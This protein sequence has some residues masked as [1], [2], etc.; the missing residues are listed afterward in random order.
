[1][2]R[3]LL[4]IL[5]VF[6]LGLIAVG[7]TFSA[8]TRGPAEFVLN[9]GTEPKSLDPALM[10]G[11][12]EGR[13][14]EG[15]FEGLA[16][17]EAKSLEP[18]PAAA[19]SWEISPD[20][21]R[22]VFHIR[23]EARWSDGRKLTAGDFAYAWRR[24]QDPSLGAEYAYI[25]HMVRYAEA[26]NLYEGQAKLLETEIAPG[27]AKLRRDN[28]SGVSP[29]AWTAFIAKHPI[30]ANIKGSPD[31]LLVEFLGAQSPALDPASLEKL[32]AAL[33]EEARRRRA[34][35]EE[36][37][38][39]FGVDGGVF[40]KDER[41]LVVELVAPTPYF[42]EIAAFYPTYPVPRWLVEAEGSEKDWF[43]PEKIVSNGAFRLVEWRVGDR[44]R[45]ER[46]ETYWGKDK[47]RLRSVDILPIEN[48]TTSLN[49]YL[50]GD[51]DWIPSNRY[52]LDLADKLKDR[53]DFYIGPALI[54][55]YYRINTTRKP[56]DD[57]RVRKALNLA[58]D[59]EQITRDVLGLGQ[60]PAGHMVPPGL[61][62]YDPPPTEIRYDVAEARRLLAEAGFSEG[63]GFPAFG[64]LYNTLEMHK[65]IAEVIADQLRR[66]LGLNVKAYNQEWQSYQETM[67]ALD[68]Y[69]GR[70]GW[71]GDYEDPN[72]FLD[73]W[74]TNGGN[75]QTG[76]GDPTYDRLIAAAADT[77]TFIAAPDELLPK[78][79]QKDAIR[80]LL[81]AV[82]S[83]VPGP[84]RLALSAKLR[85][86]LLR[87]AE[88]ILVRREFP[89]IPLYFYVNSGLVRP[90]V[91]G[92]YTEIT[93]SDGRKRPNPRDIHPLQ[94]IWIDGD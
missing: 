73:I 1:M 74:V 14:A 13:V 4:A 34:A 85:M 94:E 61:D 48:A 59:R 68:Y 45:L 52:P 93:G 87:E 36:A 51:L 30:H 18:V 70:A 88:A 37:K 27:L 23:P 69:L 58:V 39:R 72:T 46:S 57:R 62:G 50:G 43:L 79:D 2:L 35:F 75:N 56:F 10:T 32:E 83:A 26:Y 90:N 49:L 65:K 6:A 40:A 19:E 77:E 9:N 55:Y 22:Y 86:M 38:R 53:D 82:K 28:P 29:K 84:E 44:I 42:L 92:F 54:V 64:V 33:Y 24:L 31:P 5:C 89:I 11:E 66:N 47:V 7:F 80:A 76:W 25:L 21:K 60:I 78:L 16:R 67:R 12:P 17:L 91:K 8:S 41:T 20:G 81:E 63:R 3:S 15:I 71:I